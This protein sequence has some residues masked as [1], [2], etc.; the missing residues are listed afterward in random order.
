M[1]APV[2]EV[3]VKINKIVEK[4]LSKNSCFKT[5]EAI[6]NVLKSSDSQTCKWCQPY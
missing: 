6:A 4:V 1:E 2:E 3:G 5:I